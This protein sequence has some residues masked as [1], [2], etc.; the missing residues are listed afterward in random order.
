MKKWIVVFVLTF[1]GCV[2]NKNLKEGNF[3]AV[4]DKIKI[5]YTVRGEGPII[6]VGH[7]YSGKVGYEMTL[8][9]LEK[10]FTMVYYAPRGTGKSNPPASL[11]EYGYSHIVREI[12]LL[13][14]HLKAEKIWIFGHSD[15][16]EIALEYAIDFPE[17]V[18]GLI[19]SGT[20][21]I[22]NQKIETEEKRTF[23]LERRKNKWFN[24]VCEDWDYMLENNSNSDEAGRDL[25][26]TP[27]KWWCYDSV[28]AQR[29]IPVYNEIS[30]AGRRKPIA[31][32]QPFS[33]EPELEKLYKRIY[34]YQEFYY[35]IKAPILI[36]QGK[37]D[38]NNPPKLV[39]KLHLK[40]PTSTLIWVE[41]AGHFPWVEEPRES[42]DKIE[43]WL[44][45]E[46]YI[47]K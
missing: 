1:I 2:Q 27:L 34:D 41:N 11:N 43:K 46:N 21:F 47:F 15:Q 5:N 33:T 17:N 23:E 13:R 25:T 22:E 10:Y 31:S 18:A 30:K 3:D 19:L 32:Q 39:E 26:H 20:H 9:P 8:K 45:K 16:S 38:T 42:F 14:K 37:W 35:Q 28:S 44:T 6:L 12:E 7:L 36:L 29:V 40:L 4:I 24:Q